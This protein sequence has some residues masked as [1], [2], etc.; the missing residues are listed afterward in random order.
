VRYPVHIP[1]STKACRDCTETVQ[2]L[3]RDCAETTKHNRHCAESIKHNR[4]C[5]ET[6]GSIVLQCQP[7][8]VSCC[9]N[10]HGTMVTNCAQCCHN[11]HGTMATSFVQCMMGINIV[12]SHIKGQVSLESVQNSA[13]SRGIRAWSLAQVTECPKQELSK[14]RQNSARSRGIWTWSLAQVIECPKQSA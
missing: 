5:A 2:R 12:W 3:C 11:T 13:G 9:H 7:P 14:C 10:T 8:S 4:H 1:D 6:K